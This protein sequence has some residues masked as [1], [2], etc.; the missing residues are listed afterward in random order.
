MQASTAISITGSRSRLGL[1][2]GLSGCMLAVVFGA[3]AATDYGTPVVAAVIGLVVCGVGVAIYVRDPILALI[4][5]WIF[6]VFNGSLSAAVGYESSAGQAIRQADEILVLLLL[7][8]TVWRTLRTGTRIPSLGFVLPGIGVALFGVLGAIFHGVPL[9][10]TVAGAWLGL[11]FWVMVVITLLL[12]W[13]MEDLARVYSVMTRVG[14]FVAVFGLI[15]YLA[16]GAVSHTLHTSIA[17]E[18][19]GYRG[20]AIDSIF[21]H[22]GE[23]SLFMSI[24]FALTFARFG[25]ERCRSDLLL[26]L[27]FAGSVLLSLRLKGFLSLAAVVIIVALALNMASNRG[28]ITVL[29]AGGLLLVGVYSVEGNVI[30]RQISTYTSSE[31]TA[32]ARLYATGERIAQEDSP[33]GVGFGRFASYPSRVFYSPVYYQYGLGSVYGLGPTGPD[34]IDDTSWPT[35]IGETGYG[36]LL[37]YV[38]GVMFLILSLIG[39]LRATA[40]TLKWVQLAALCGIAVML[41]DSLGSPT[42][43]DWIATTSFA[44][45]FGPA[46]LVTQSSSRALSRS[47]PD[48]KIAGGSCSTSLIGHAIRSRLV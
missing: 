7:V 18:G 41:V 3:A 6:E 28:S 45:V 29:L 38:G 21:T 36:G 16:H 31:T 11:K 1:V 15:D 25:V 19:R 48:A 46:M 8:L 37:I 22:P 40:G 13:K 39:R 44:M 4:G 27:I 9:T 33:L 24:L 20:N 47:E 10:V 34:F 5:L 26:A 12:P 14:V 30:A 23:Y 32:R 43:F 17:H 42:L 35:V 2:I